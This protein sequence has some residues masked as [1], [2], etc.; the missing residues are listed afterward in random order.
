MKK[1]FLIMCATAGLLCSCTTVKQTASEQ[2]V[3]CNIHSEVYATMNVS[4]TKISYKLNTT[5][6]I[7]RGGLQN[8][9]NTAI[10]EALKQHGD[11][12]VLIQTEKTIVERKGMFGRKIRSVTVTGYPAKYINFENM[13]Q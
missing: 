3:N 12:D 4:N 1:L 9:I 8:C 7:R 13:P 10:H 11:A 5:K 2:D 6:S